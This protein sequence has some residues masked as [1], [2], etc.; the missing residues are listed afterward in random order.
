MSEKKDDAQR[1]AEELAEKLQEGN[2]LISLWQFEFVEDVADT[3]RA[4]VADAVEG[5]DRIMT[6]LLGKTEAECEMWRQGAEAMQQAIY[7]RLHLIAAYL[8]IWDDIEEAVKEAKQPEPPSQS[9]SGLVLK[10]SRIALEREKYRK[11]LE[12]IGSLTVVLESHADCGNVAVA[13]N[14]I[15]KE[16]LEESH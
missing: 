6:D 10:P 14:R 1:R 4:A 3:I 15:A 16:A 8:M 7:R 9:A 11:A 2:G 12:R 13:S 5:R